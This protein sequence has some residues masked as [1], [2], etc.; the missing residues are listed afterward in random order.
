MLDP[1]AASDFQAQV[2]KNIP[3]L[4]T[5]H[6]CYKLRNIPDVAAGTDATIQLQYWANY[7]DGDDNAEREKFY[8]CADIVRLLASLT[9]GFRNVLT[10]V[11]I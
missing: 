9:K 1:D 10:F 11:T 6:Q 4:E 2:V 7:D 8:A 5:G 3:E